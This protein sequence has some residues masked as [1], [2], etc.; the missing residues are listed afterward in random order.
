[1]NGAERAETLQHARKDRVKGLD[2]GKSGIEGLDL[3]GL[4]V[5]LCGS[6]ID[7]RG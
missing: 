4:F 7:L 5:A 1:M 3:G 2:G 6:W